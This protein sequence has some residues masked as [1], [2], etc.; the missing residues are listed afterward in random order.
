MCV[1]GGG[2]LIYMLVDAGTNEHDGMFCVCV[3]ASFDG[4]IGIARSS[5]KTTLVFAHIAH[6]NNTNVQNARQSRL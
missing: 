4:F 5:H 1:S 2:G 3:H 6:Y